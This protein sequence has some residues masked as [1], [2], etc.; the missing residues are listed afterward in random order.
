MK[1]FSL[2][3]FL[4]AAC[5]TPAPST[6]VVRY[7]GAEN[8]ARYC[9]ACHGNSGRGNGPVADAMSV[10]V[11]DLTRIRER[12]DGEFPREALIRRIDGRD[13]IDAHGSPQMP[14]WGYEFYIDEGPGRFSEE[15]VQET[16]NSIVD[17]LEALQASGDE[18]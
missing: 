6:E 13:Q 11:P 14:V 10:P 3:L 8:F 18:A 5:T 17:Y 9:A 15:G 1:R 2:F 4:L 7:T 16:L 12:N